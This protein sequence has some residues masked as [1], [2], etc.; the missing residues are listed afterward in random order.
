MKNYFTILLAVAF[1]SLSNADTTQTIGTHTYHYDLMA[2]ALDVG[3]ITI[4]IVGQADGSYVVAESTS[5]EAKGWWGDISEVSTKIENYSPEGRFLNA[6]VKTLSGKKVF[7]RKAVLSGDELWASYTQV[8]NVSEK[9]EGEFLG[10]AVAVASN[11]VA[12]LGNVLAVTQLLFSDNDAPLDNLRIPANTYDT[13]FANLPFYWTSKEHSLPAELK[14]FDSSTLAI[15]TYQVEYLGTKT[16]Q[17]GSE[18]SVVVA[19]HFKFVPE[20]GAD[21][22][23]WFA[24]NTNNSPYFYQLAGADE[25][26]PFQ[27]LLTQR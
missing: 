16:F 1:S 3:D 9:E 21:L 10:T 22:E 20:K 15:D 7:W 5:V 18:E 12:G 25:D 13:S 27:I 11:L 4:K 26:G 24:V 23:I 2:E 17:Q 6:D 8:E 19:S 14:L